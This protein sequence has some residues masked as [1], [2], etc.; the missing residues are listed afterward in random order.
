MAILIVIVRIFLVEFY[1]IPSGSMEPTILIGD[2]IFVSK[3]NCGS[4]TQKPSNA[5]FIRLKSFGKIKRLDILVFNLPDIES[6][7]FSTNYPYGEVFI[8]MLLFERKRKE[9]LNNLYLYNAFFPRDTNF[10]WN[11]DNFGP[12]VVP[13]KGQSLDINF[14]NI[15]LYNSIIQYENNKV[16]LRDTLIY[17]NGLKTFCYTFKNNYYFMLGDNFYNSHDSR[18]WGFLPETHII[19]KAVFVLYSTD[20][21]KPW[22]KAFRWERFLKKVK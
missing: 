22:Y 3:L 5:E 8:K 4:R 14:H 15:S 9:K 10:K 6:K 12:I 19:G 13:A 18:Y 7:L 2:R 11:L 17:I 1:S 16:E 21:D 20:S